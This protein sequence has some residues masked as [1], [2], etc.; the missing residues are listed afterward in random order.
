MSRVTDKIT[1]LYVRSR[2]QGADPMWWVEELVT[3]EREYKQLLT[4]GD[5]IKDWVNELRKNNPEHMAWTQ[6][7]KN[8]IN[9]QRE[10]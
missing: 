6:G 2:L 1:E 10:R 7:S 5:I 4:T 3:T 9:R 8:S